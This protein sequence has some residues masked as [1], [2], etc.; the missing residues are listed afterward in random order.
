MVSQ[1]KNDVD[2][3]VQNRATKLI[4]DG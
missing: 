4:S 2:E 1:K 3:R